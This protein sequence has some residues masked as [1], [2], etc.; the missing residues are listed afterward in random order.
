MAAG[1]LPPSPA[2]REEARR[3]G[4]VA[5]S[6]LL[7]GA[8]AVAGGGLALVGMAG[9][10]AARLALLA[11]KAFSGELAADPSSG[12]MVV[13]S[14][15]SWIVLPV[16][17]AA[18]AAAVAAGAAQTR[19]LFTLGAF[20]RREREEEAGLVGWTVAGALI[21][22]AIL[23]GRKAL[24]GLPALGGL[25]PRAVLLLAAGGAADLLLRRAR[26]ER[27]LSMTRAERRAEQ[28]EEEGDPRL[29]A[30]RRRRQRAMAAMGRSLVD[31]LRRAQV[32][33][34]AEGVALALLQEGG[35][36]RVV[37]AGD[38]LQALRIVEVAR[39]LGIPVRSDD[40]L[41]SALAELKAGAWV[42]APHQ[43]R[44]LALIPR[45]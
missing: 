30:E 22:F 33:L 2:R 5:Y 28:R 38:R 4:R 12:P 6:P 39:R 25:W 1:E 42:P 3:Q 44:A 18:L 10:A 27:S 9:P 7:T 24:A 36:V 34:A 16:A 14:T 20:G 32:V 8:A 11:K 40:R 26:L 43:P 13:L 15:V 35:G 31:D 23:S 21:L 19:G 17:A 41:A 45:R 29:K 37:L